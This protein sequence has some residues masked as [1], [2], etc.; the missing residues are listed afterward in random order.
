MVVRVGTENGRTLPVRRVDGDREDLDMSLILSS[1]ANRRVF[2]LGSLVHLDD[3]YMTCLWDY[4]VEHIKGRL[5]SGEG[6]N[7][8][9]YQHCA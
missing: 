9:D 6:G 2:S 5:A 1:R 3:D 7:R 8:R 4:E